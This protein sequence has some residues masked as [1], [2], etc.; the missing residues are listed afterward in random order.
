MESTINKA[1]E[2]K[3]IKSRSC[4]DYLSNRLRKRKSRFK[5][6]YLDLVQI[7][8]FKG[9]NAI[10]YHTD[11]L[12]ERL[13]SY[14]EKI[15]CIDEEFGD[16][17]LSDLTKEEMVNLTDLTIEIIKLCYAPESAI[18]GFKGS[19]LTALLHACFPELL[20][21]MDRRVLISTGLLEEGDR[22]GNDIK[23]GF[24]QAN[25]IKYYP[26]LIKEFWKE[27]KPLHELDRKYF[28]TDIPKTK[29]TYE[30]VK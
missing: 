3:W 2:D 15:N 25:T 14:S 8:N 12:K 7:S 17:K 6:T 24:D 27:K 13:K 16:K 18:A 10:V 28:S 19:Y 20:P 9:G 4:L 26:E 11:D 1:Q 30:T 5:L 21:I 29:N 22:K 23:N